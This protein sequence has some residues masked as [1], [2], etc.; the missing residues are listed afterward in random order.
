M[1]STNVAL[2]ILIHDEVFHE[3]EKEV[4]TWAELG[5]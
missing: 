2:L 1:T 3:S 5:N 4:K